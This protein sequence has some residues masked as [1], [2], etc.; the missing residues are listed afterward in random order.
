MEYKNVRASGIKSES[1]LDRIE[2]KMDRILHLLESGD[3]STSFERE[4]SEG[5]KKALVGLNR[6]LQSRYTSSKQ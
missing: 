6:V 5:S 2:K 4:F 1:Q 3:L